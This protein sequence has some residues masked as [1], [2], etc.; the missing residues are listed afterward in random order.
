MPGFGKTPQ[1]I[2]PTDIVLR[3]FIKQ[4]DLD[5]PVLVGPSMGGR[6]SLEFAINY[7]ELAGGL[8]VTSQKV[9]AIPGS[10]DF[11]SLRGAQS[12]RY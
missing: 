12:Q 3:D 5:R 10:Y 2:N 7:P 11:P 4:E 9:R 6:I 8:V 1:C